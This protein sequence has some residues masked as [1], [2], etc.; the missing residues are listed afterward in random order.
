MTVIKLECLYCTAEPLHLQCY[1]DSGRRPGNFTYEGP[2]ADVS[3]M[4]D[5]VDQHLDSDLKHELGSSAE[6]HVLER[7]QAPLG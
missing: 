6:K 5:Q 4:L 3:T 1:T 7:D 2:G